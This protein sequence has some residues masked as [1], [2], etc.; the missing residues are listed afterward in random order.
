MCHHHLDAVREDEEA[1]EE[2]DPEPAQA[3]AEEGRRER[4]AYVPPT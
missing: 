4:L 1:A 3:A 2:A